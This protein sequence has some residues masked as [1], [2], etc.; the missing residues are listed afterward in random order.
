MN[1]IDDGTYDVEYEH[2]NSTILVGSVTNMLLVVFKWKSGEI[3]SNCTSCHGYYMI[4]VSLSPYKLKID[5]NI[6]G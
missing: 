2:I 3:Y 1:I 5:L 4:K 6:Y